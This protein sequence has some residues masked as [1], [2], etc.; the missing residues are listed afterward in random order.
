MTASSYAIEACWNAAAAALLGLLA[1]AAL[2]T[3]LVVGEGETPGVA[4]LPL[5]G[6]FMSS[7]PLMLP[8]LGCRDV[9]AGLLFFI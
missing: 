5:S 6:V 2:D 7:L 3:L 4:V 1:P 9:P 8:T